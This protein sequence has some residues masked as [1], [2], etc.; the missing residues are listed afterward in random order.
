[1]ILPLIV[2]CALFMEN[3]DTSALATTLPAIAASMNESPLQV[4]MAISTYLLSIAVF[5]P[6]SGWIADR[7]GARNVFRAAI[8]LFVLGSIFCGFA[9]TTWQLVAARALQGVGGALM[10]P[11]G[12]LVVLRR[13]PKDQLVNAMAWISMP[14][15]VA[16]VVR[17]LVGGFFATYTTWRWIF[18]INLPIGVLGYLL[19]T[20]HL[21]ETGRTERP[22][23]LRGWALFGGGLAALVY[24]LENAGK[25]ILATW[26]V[27]ALLVLGVLLV[28]AYL[29]HARRHPHPIV[30][31]GLLRI[32]TFAVS[33]AGGALFRIAVGASTL[34]MPLMLQVGFGLTAMQSGSLTF[35]GA[36]GAM[37]MR[38]GVARLLR[39]VGFRRLLLAD[40]V[41][42]AALLVLCG[43]LAPDTPRTAMLALFTVIGFSRSLMFSCV[44]TMAYADIDEK[45]MS[46]ATSLAGTAQQLA[47][48]LGVCFGA[49]ALHVSALV[50]G[51][52]SVLQPRDFS[53][54]FWAAALCALTAVLVYQRLRPDAGR[55]VSGHRSTS[56]R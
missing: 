36:L 53:L 38:G 24:A 20:R 33:L 13:I 45:Q 30:D 40:A 49:Q 29:A 47:L 42:S 44:N 25:G 7:Y 43:F 17:P 31:L 37:V 21:P 14:G 39:R 2:A 4:S 11:V 23:D 10:V 28:G 54:S 9:I 41:V 8:A 6:V 26:L 1:M 46:H 35:V 5:I 50:R 16:P 27:L 51:D 52:E 15:L 56:S 19:A 12:R 22:L 34:L 55:S 3:L 18:F 32:P 48:A